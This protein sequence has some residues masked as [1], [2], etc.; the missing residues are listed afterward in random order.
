MSRTTS[1]NRYETRHESARRQLFQFAD[2]NHIHIRGEHFPIKPGGQYDLNLDSAWH[3]HFESGYNGVGQP[4]S[5]PITELRA[6]LSELYYDKRI[7][8]VFTGND[9]LGL[10]VFVSTFSLWSQD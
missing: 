7:H 3:W 8:F 10:D 6:L 1:T 4:Y 5:I 9:V 2:D